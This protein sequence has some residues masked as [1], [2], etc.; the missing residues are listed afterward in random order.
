MTA[1]WALQWCDEQQ[2]L[3]FALER[4]SSC[5]EMLFPESCRS[6][7]CCGT[8][9]R[10]FARSAAACPWVCCGIMIGS[11]VSCRLH[12][13]CCR[14]HSVQR[15]HKPSGLHHHQQQWPIQRDYHLPFT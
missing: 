7:I 13:R 12:H 15:P 10:C 3:L 4:E 8:F 11:T 6:I 9:I 14:Q 1:I 5:A 2:A